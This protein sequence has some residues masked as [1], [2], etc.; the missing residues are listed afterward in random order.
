MVFDYQ[1]VPLSQIDSNDATF[2]ITSRHPSGDLAASI[3]EIGL[4][5]PPFLK[6]AG[7]KYVIISGFA[8]IAACRQLGWSSITAGLMDASATAEQCTIV[9]VAD[10]TAHRT[11]NL[12]EQA[13]AVNLLAGAFHE[14]RAFNAAAR[15]AGLDISERLIAKLKR[16]AKLPPLVQSGLIE[17]IIALPVALAIDQ[18]PDKAA[19]TAVNQLLYES[20]FSLNQQREILDSVIAVSHRDGISIPRLLS[21]GPI[22]DI[23]RNGELDHRHKARM[24]RLSLKAMRYPT[25]S[26][27]EKHFQHLVQKLKLPD[28]AQLAAPPNFERRSF[29]L[30][31]EFDNQNDLVAMQEVL[32]RLI[33]APEIK[34]LWDLYRLDEA[35]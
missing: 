30:R 24:I 19:A 10:K 32:N 3:R 28:K 2:C 7:D 8:R 22:G 29:A 16:V 14:K 18:M 1:S 35:P 6:A 26:S 31:F 27:V 25:I 20:N 34:Q 11:L 9:A 15:R 13:H 12:V 33:S 4:L 17:G 23:R 21:D 5:R